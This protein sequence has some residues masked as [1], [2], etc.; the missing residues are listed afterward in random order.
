MFSTPIWLIYVRTQAYDYL[1]KFKSTHTLIHFNHNRLRTCQRR[2]STKIVSI[3]V[4]FEALRNVFRY[5]ILPQHSNRPHS[6]IMFMYC[7]SLGIIYDSSSHERRRR[8]NEERRERMNEWVRAKWSEAERW[9]K[10]RTNTAIKIWRTCIER[11]VGVWM[12]WCMRRLR[13]SVHNSSL[14]R[15]LPLMLTFVDFLYV[16][17][18]APYT[19]VVNHSE[20]WV[21]MCVSVCMCLCVRVFLLFGALLL[22][23]R[24]HANKE[25]SRVWRI[26]R[27]RNSRNWNFSFGV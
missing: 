16:N 2:N 3:I 7:T 1:L 18:S 17:Q 20:C 19:N 27:C 5:L 25:N 13:V 15:F 14:R 8:W 26:I 4:A 12:C 10:Q 23:V 24:E 9:A 11:A 21:C 22:Y 6:R